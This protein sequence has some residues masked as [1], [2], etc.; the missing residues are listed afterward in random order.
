MAVGRYLGL[1]TAS[2]ASPDH[3]D[4]DFRI[5]L[6][7]D[8]EDLNDIRAA[9]SDLTLKPHKP[10]WR[11]K[12]SPT[13]CFWTL[14][15]SFVSRQWNGTDLAEKS[16]RIDDTSYLNGLRG[17]GALVVVIQH[18]TH[19]YYPENAGCYG[20]GPPETDHFVQL[21]F[22]RILVDGSFSVAL[23]FV[24]SGFALSYGP[25]KRIHANNPEA[26]VAAMPSSIFRRPIRLFLP[27][28]PVYVFSW[29]L[30]QGQWMYSSSAYV[31]SP[32]GT[33]GDLI[34]RQS[35]I[36]MEVWKGLQQFAS[37]DTTGLEAL[38]F[39]QSWTLFYEHIGSL[40]VF[41]FCIA[42]ARTTIVT[43]MIGVATSALYSYYTG[44][45]LGWAGFLFLGGMLLAESRCIRAS[46]K[47]FEPAPAGSTSLKW[48]MTAGST[49]VLV[50]AMFFGS[51]PE[52]GDAA[53]CVGFK[54]FVGIVLGTAPEDYQL[55]MVGL[56]ALATVCALESLPSLQQLFNTAPVRYLGDI[57]YSLYLVHVA[58][59]YS[60]S[61][62]AALTAMGAGIGKSVACVGI[63]LPITL[64][65]GF[66]L[67]DLHWRFVDSQSVKL[68]RW[69]SDKLG[70]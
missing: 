23:F 38:Y 13:R 54:H 59:A 30:I 68:S 2:P 12:W 19:E 32:E 33:P 16:A 39:P 65:T 67:A 29:I 49:L 66:W 56:S 36:F 26:A 41:L 3:R 11:S 17:I 14:L 53:R 15:P 70:V 51:W 52:D 46:G 24:I 22:V 37:I 64:V 55:Y 63:A 4:A 28:F 20:D 6:E 61:K 8:T 50:M 42:F 10:S 40:I 9:D 31:M 25:L 5:S 34:A 57:S 18:T 43:R 58:V 1:E 69:A 35:N 60:W 21:P 7:P 27:V 48:L 44:G 45:L 47:Y 62:T